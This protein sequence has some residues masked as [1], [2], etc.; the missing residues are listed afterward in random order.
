MIFVCLVLYWSLGDASATWNAVDSD[1]KSRQL[2]AMRS[3][4]SRLYRDPPLLAFQPVERKEIW[5]GR[6]VDSND[7]IAAPMK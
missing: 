7:E 4:C 3:N 2:Y 5:S 6:G 1:I